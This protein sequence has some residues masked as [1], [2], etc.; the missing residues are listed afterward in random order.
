[1]SDTAALK[2]N[3][4][5]WTTKVTHYLELIRF[6]HTIF[7]LPFALLAT[8]WAF[9]VPLPR[10]TA[11][12]VGD[13]EYLPFRW[14]ALLGI[15]ICMISARSFAMAINRLFDQKWDGE[16]PRTASRHLPAKLLTRSG[17]ILFCVGCATVFVAACTLFLPNQLPLILCVPVLCFLAG[18][19]LGK[20]FTNLVH[21]W[22]GVALM[23]APM[24]AW[25]AL[26]GE[27]LMA[28]PSDLL[29]AMVL[30]LVVFLWVSGFDIIYSCQDV[31]YDRS[32]GLF[33]I[34][35]WLGVRQALRVSA[36]CHALMWSLALA[37][38]FLFPNLSLGWLFQSALAIIGVCLIYEHSVVSDKSLA[39][40]QLAFFQLNSV[41][42]I[43][44]LIVGTL[45]AYWRN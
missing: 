39:R 17:V 9:V 12:S 36:V 43:L 16:N 13:N 33:S 32:A 41:I 3:R 15:L 18:Y 10:D 27:F 34:P 31:D 7:A 23:L 8:A 38:T 5:Q 45:D 25:I 30:G 37:M 21:F 28:N 19:S 2:A 29:P 11:S 35:A 26:R 6:S 24:C 14:G 1:M 44:F 22:L 40:I 20:R 4:S 42:S